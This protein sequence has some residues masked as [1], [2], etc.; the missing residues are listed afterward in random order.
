MVRGWRASVVVVVSTPR[1]P[2]R[3]READFSASSCRS[4]GQLENRERECEYVRLCV[5]VCFC[6]CIPSGSH[7]S[8]A[9]GIYRDV[10]RDKVGDTRNDVDDED[11]DDDDGRRG[12]RRANSVSAI[13]ADSAGF[14]KTKREGKRELCQEAVRER[15]RRSC[16]C[17]RSGCDR[18]GMC[19]V[20]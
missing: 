16:W 6:G 5:A 4:L 10:E 15:H 19:D 9:G 8:R 3:G 7:S 11:E 13:A 2:G 20:G 14:A 17:T 12:R 18:G 1:R